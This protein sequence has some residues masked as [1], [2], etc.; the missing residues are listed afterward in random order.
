MNKVLYIILI[1][2]FSLTIIS[3]AKQDDAATTTSG[4]DTTT[5]GD[6]TTTSGDDTTTSDDDTTTTT[7][8]TT[9][10]TVTG[11]IYQAISVKKKP[12]K[13]SIKYTSLT[14]KPT[15]TNLNFD[16]A[17]FGNVKFQ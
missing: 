8:T 17:Q 10:D 4:D 9:T 13:T 1:S 14:A 15:T 6:D 16:N 5:S 3:C 11:V 12:K 7:T 2:L